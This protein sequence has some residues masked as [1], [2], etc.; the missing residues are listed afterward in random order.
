MGGAFLV[1]PCSAV[2]PC[3]YRYRQSQSPRLIN[4]PPKKSTL[5]DVQN[6]NNVVV[7]GYQKTE[8]QGE[9]TALS[10]KKLTEQMRKRISPRHLKD[11]WQASA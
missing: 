2:G 1:V 11:K 3:V 7:T 10:T 5:D 8:C 9:P 4:S 6:L